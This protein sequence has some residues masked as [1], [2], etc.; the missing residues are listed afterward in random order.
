MLRDAQARREYPGGFGVRVV[1]DGHSLHAREN[2]SEKECRDQSHSPTVMTLLMILLLCS[3][4]LVPPS[5]VC[6]LSSFSLPFF[7]FD[8]MN[9]RILNKNG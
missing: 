9:G 6:C 7:F 1:E 3:L 8:K 5:R 2:N 4:R